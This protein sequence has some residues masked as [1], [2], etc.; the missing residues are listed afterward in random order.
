MTMP[1]ERYSAIIRTR[2]FLQELRKAPSKY[3]AEEIKKEIH[4]CL[5]HYPSELY[6]DQLADLAPNILEKE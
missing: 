2:D 3:S 6:L 4:R 5:K 1:N